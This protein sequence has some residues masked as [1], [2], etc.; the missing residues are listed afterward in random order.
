MPIPRPAGAPRPGPA[1]SYHSTTS[2][3]SAIAI[4]IADATQIIPPPEGMSASARAVRAD[5]AAE[6]TKRAQTRATYRVLFIFVRDR[7][8]A[9]DAQTDDRLAAEDDEAERAL[10]LL[11]GAR[12]G[13]AGPLLRPHAAELLAVG[14]DEVHVPVEREHLARERAPV[15]DR[16]FEPPVDEREHFSALGFRRRLRRAGVLAISGSGGWGE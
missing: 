3:S 5:M 16:H 8:R 11:H 7:R 1:G 2:Q 12:L 10:H 4:T 13:L 14:E 6:S 15:V 9:L